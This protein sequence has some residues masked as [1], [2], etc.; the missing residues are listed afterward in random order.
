MSGPEGSRLD[1]ATHERIYTDEVLPESGFFK[2]TAQAH[3]KAVVLAGQ[4][5]A[6]KGGLA[7]AAQREFKGD[8]II[9]DF[10]KNRGY[11]PD[12]DNLRETYP[13]TWAEHTQHDA[14][15]W[16]NKLRSDVIEGRRNIILDTTLSHPKS[17]INQIESL[18]KNGYAVEV[19]VIAAHRLESELGVDK[20]FTDGL[21]RD[22]HGRH[23]PKEFRASSY[24]ALPAS[25]DQVHAETGARIRIYNREGQELYDSQNSKLKPGEALEQAREARMQDPALVRQT[26]KNW[27]GQEEFHRELPA[28]LEQLQQNGRIN[29][30]TAQNLPPEHRKLGIEKD[31]QSYT[32]EAI[33]VDQAVRIEPAQSRLGATLK[34]VGVADAR[35]AVTPEFQTFAKGAGVVGAGLMVYDAVDTERKYAALSAQGNQLGADALLH[36]YVGR[37]GGGLV[38][39]FAA[40]AAYGAATGSWTGPGALVT[41][42]VGGAIGAFG[43]EA[44]AKA[45]TQYEMNHQVG[46]DGHTYAYANGKWETS[47]WIHQNQPAP[48]DQIATLEYKRVSAVT[49]LALA[50]PQHLDTQNITLTDAHGQKTEYSHTKTGWVTQVIDSVQVPNDLGIIG[51]HNEPAPPELGKQLDRISA[52]RHDANAHY[53]E[54]LAKAYMTDYVGRGFARDDRPVPEAVTNALRLPSEI[55]VKDPVTGNVWERNPKGEFTRTQY[56]SVPGPEGPE[57][58][59]QVLTAKGPELERLG[60]EQQAH[61]Q[62]NRKY[63]AGLVAQKF[64]EMQQQSQQQHQPA[65]Q[66]RASA[67]PAPTTDHAGPAPQP[68]HASPAATHNESGAHPEHNAHNVQ[69]VHNAHNV[70]NVNNTSNASNARHDPRLAE[71]AALKAE[72]AHHLQVAELKDQIA[73]LEAHLSQPDQPTLH[74]G[75]S[76]HPQAQAAAHPAQATPGADASRGYQAVDH[77]VT[78][79]AAQALPQQHA[80]VQQQPAPGRSR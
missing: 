55:H 14:G 57:F 5:G 13:Y 48:Q 62:S 11:H 40:G 18:K 31:A 41:G 25:L 10:D 12:I 26:V 37:T 56:A 3:P 71:I 50:N 42:A 45:Y 52:A 44:I 24:E 79:H 8:G 51:T 66:E 69:D 21:A 63:G 74:G 19:R 20:R 29:A 15:K 64:Q 30:Q 49:E 58:V 59:P 76:L 68:Q 7:K 16:T 53:T 4:P 34:Q 60:Q 9:I 61:V 23:V 65:G 54:N 2:T 38:G 77:N 80:Q 73:K 17:G 72:I 43:G 35:I 47:N 78:Q 67:H 6:G 32:K 27:R 46:N 39:G 75:P 22:G 70:A 36:D 28:T 1:Q 33:A